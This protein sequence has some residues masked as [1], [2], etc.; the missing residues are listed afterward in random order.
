MSG[1]IWSYL[2]VPVSIS[3]WR[4]NGGLRD[5]NEFDEFGYP[6]DNLIIFE[7]KFPVE[8][9]R[10]FFR[11]YVLCGIVLVSLL[12]LA[13]KKYRPGFTLFTKDVPPLCLT[14]LSTFAAIRTMTFQMAIYKE[15]TIKSSICRQD[16]H[17][18]DGT[19]VY[20]FL[21]ATLNLYWLCSKFGSNSNLEIIRSG[22]IS[23]YACYSFACGMAGS[24]WWLTSSWMLL[25]MNL[26]AD[27]DWHGV[28]DGK[29]LQ[30]VKFYVLKIVGMGSACQVLGL[31]WQML[32]L[33]EYKDGI[34]CESED[35]VLALQSCWILYELKKLFWGSFMD[36][37]SKLLDKVKRS[38]EESTAV[39]ED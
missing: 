31:A 18:A 20:S 15:E 1:S 10:A 21:Y 34:N 24:A 13:M 38:R 37:N 28:F 23:F 9:V 2:A 4:L 39:K 8:K 6:H 36:W 17:T 26:L 22:L 7:T 19:S 32:R 3:L 35:N 5:F 11:E 12:M 29:W 16:I 33:W 14:I 27:M 25:S 30:G